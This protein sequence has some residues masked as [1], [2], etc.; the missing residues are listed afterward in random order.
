M[1]WDGQE[2]DLSRMSEWM[3]VCMC[4]CARAC[5]KISENA[6]FCIISVSFSLKLFHDFT[7]ILWRFQFFFKYL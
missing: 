4:V 5:V 2:N 6:S 7:R 1:M 3:C